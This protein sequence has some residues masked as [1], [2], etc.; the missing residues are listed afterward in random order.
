MD[1]NQFFRL[2]K[3]N[4]LLLIGVPIILV[5]SVYFFSQNQ[6]KAYVSETTIYT[7]IASGYSIENQSRTNVDF[8]GTNM[9][10]YNLI[11]I[12][13]SRS[14]KEQTAI[15]LL[16]QHLSLETSNSQYISQNNY[17]ELQKIVPKEVKDLVVK[18]GKTGA[19]RDKIKQIRQ[20]EE[21]IQHMERELNRMKNHAI[22]NSTNNNTS[23]NNSSQSGSRGDVISATDTLNSNKYHLVTYGES[24]SAIANQYGL[25]SGQLIRMNNLQGGSLK[26][27]DRLLISADDSDASS[28]NVGSNQSSAQN[29]YHVVRP[30]ET[31]YSIARDNNVSL[32]DL[33]GWNNIQGDKLSIGSTI[34]VGKEYPDNQETQSSKSDDEIRNYSE[35]V[36]NEFRYIDPDQKATER[37]AKDAIVPPG[38][39]E[40]DFY[41]TVE[42]LTA[43]YQSSDSNF[44]YELLQYGH[45]HYSVGAISRAQVARVQNSDLVKIT[46]SSNDPGICQQTLKILTGVFIQNYKSLRA[47]QTDQVVKYFEEEVR[48]A[49]QRLKDAEDRLLRFNQENNL[50]NYNEQT[51]AIAVQKEE[52]DK[53]YQDKMVE[54]R[55]AA[56]SLEKMEAK[57]IKKDSIFLK[58]DMITNKRREL[59]KVTEKLVINQVAEDYDQITSQGVRDLRREKQRL[60]DDINLYL[61]QLFMYQQ[62]I[63]GVPISDLLNAWLENVI[64]YE[65]AKAS[66]NVLQQRKNEFKRIYAI[67]APLGAT[68]KRIEREINVSEQEYLELLRSLNEARMR[69]QNLEMSSNIK[70]VDPPYYPLTVSG[71]NTR[72]LMLAA[73]F[74]G[75]ILV[76]FVILVL[77]YFDSSNKTPDRLRKAT[78]LPMAGIFPDLDIKDE[79]LDMPY[80]ISRV[81]EIIIQNLSLQLRHTSVNKPT[82]PYFIL[83]FSTQSETGKTTVGHHLK[84]KLESLDSNVLYMNYKQS[85]DLGQGESEYI[86]DINNR[87]F[88]IN[89]V[90]QLLDSAALRSDNTE[91]DYIL[92][93]IPSIIHNSYPLDLMKTIDG[94]ILI[95]KANDSWQKADQMA[96]DNFMKVSQEE[97]MFVLNKADKYAIDEILH[98][99]PSTGRTPWNRFKRNVTAP[100]RLRIKFKDEE[101]QNK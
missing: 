44:I 2:L 35:Y 72:I 96:L 56:A 31:L 10:F 78:S 27:G 87:F 88:E 7:G 21:E 77:E 92:L 91:Y 67:F 101:E 11:N 40:E 61:D 15:R 84:D 46:Y 1:F 80:V 75:F 22:S 100:F 49:A 28:G 51:E 17:N 24:I 8:Y 26:V 99:V 90:R 30:K 41:R 16:A 3:A 79:N 29:K 73:A 39:E 68:L 19:E 86:Y 34:I 42:N 85:R 36:I 97:P 50:I 47:R 57:L 55:A 71:S 5:I 48:K 20:H 81:T 12:I 52:L 65:S 45:P 69:Q 6:P 66:L 37:R 14:T 33:R 95:S 38:V 82:K 94:S 23:D 63:E 9:Q 74:L 83:L 54:M 58:S 59:S 98:G 64:I 62:S 13:N 18:F 76:A 89:H 60:E 93:E 43:Y 25:S 70:V 53:T 4:L 32:N